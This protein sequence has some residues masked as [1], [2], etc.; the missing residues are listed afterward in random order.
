M[1]EDEFRRALERLQSEH[2]GDVEKK[3]AEIRRR[4]RAK[5]FEAQRRVASD[6]H[7]LIAVRCPRQVG[8]T[9]FIAGEILCALTQ[10]NVQVCYITLIREQAKR[11]IW[12]P[13]M[14]IAAE[15]GWEL[16]EQE[17]ELI[18]TAPETGSW[19]ILRGCQDMADVAKFEG[20]FYDKVF[21][22]EAQAFPATVIKRL[23]YNALLPTLGKKGGQL[24]ITGRPNNIFYGEF[25]EVTSPQAEVVYLGKD[26]KLRSRSRPWVERHDKKWEGVIFAYSLH[27][28]TQ[29]D[30]TAEPQ[31]WES[32]KQL[33][34]L[35][36][37]PDDHPTWMRESLGLWATDESLLVYRFAEGERLP[38]AT[39][40][41]HGTCWKRI[42]VEPHLRQFNPFGL[43]IPGQR[44]IRYAIG[45][46]LG[47]ADESRVS[48]C[49][50]SPQWPV[51]YGA[52]YEW[53]LAGGNLTLLAKH[54]AMAV[55]YCG[56]WDGDE[57]EPMK[58]DVPYIGLPRAE[59]IGRKLY[60]YVKIG[61]NRVDG[62]W[63]DAEKFGG[64]VLRQMA[65][66]Y[67][68]VIK[69]AKKRHKKDHIEALNTD[70]ENGKYLVLLGSVTAGEMAV[71]SWDET[72]MK[73]KSG[74][75]NNAC[76]AALYAG[77]NARHHDA[78][79]LV[80]KPVVQGNDL[81][82]QQMMERRERMMRP[83]VEDAQ[84]NIGMIAPIDAY[85]GW[86]WQ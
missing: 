82:V 10:P 7:R 32:S 76:D 70:T 42:E 8:K 40:W 51:A 61:M 69:E 27:S 78:T 38:G 54:V 31:I 79:E 28:W 12:A 63:A 66:D 59:T 43:P 25:F 81:V 48:V 77:C 29:Q 83:P 47:D 11:N 41:K 30:N 53:G 4:I 65:R 19:V 17:S 5:Y 62:F 3:L 74:Q 56:G 85:D 37:W 68:I 45:L 26:E 33:K 9:Y 49:G 16:Y 71:L 58:L 55:A 15:V 80:E 14:K 73:E 84:A 64:L 44:P 18:I 60:E 86:D 21:I 39:D 57:G 67:G 24:Y 36:G 23:I 20:T 52:A 35:N 22:D 1:T 2:A 75:K 6:P 46:D 72:R 34:E 50:Y 13:I